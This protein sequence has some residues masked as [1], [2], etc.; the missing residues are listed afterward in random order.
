MNYVLGKDTRSFV[1]GYGNN[2][3]TKPHHRA[4][5]CPKRPR[6]CGLEEKASSGPNPQ[7]LIGA[8]VGGPDIND[9]FY[10]DRN[11][12]KQSEVALDLIVKEMSP[13]CIVR[14]KLLDH[15]GDYCWADPF[16]I[17][18]ISIQYIK[19]ILL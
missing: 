8:V 5:S 12:Y 13:V 19:N 3:P 10:D 18:P 2:P 17:S 15:I 16:P 7:L 4:S 6:P 9:R 14:D 1:V 11:N